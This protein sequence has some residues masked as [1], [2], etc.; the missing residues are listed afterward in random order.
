MFNNFINRYDFT[1]FILGLRHG[2]LPKILS[3][4]TKGKVGR[5]KEAWKDEKEKNAKATTWW[6]IPAICQRYNHL[7]T[8]NENVDY[9]HYVAS[10]Y[11]NG[12]NGLK[13]LSLGCGTGHRERMWACL[14]DFKKIEGYDISEGLIQKAREEATKKDFKGILE[15]QAADILKLDFKENTYDAIFVEHSLHH[16]SPLED[17]LVKINNC[18]KPDGFFV[19]NE[20]VGP[21]RFQWTDRQLE[22]ANGVLSILPNKYRRHV[23][24]GHQ[25]KKIIR[26]S[27]LSMI[28]KDPSEAIESGEIMPLIEKTFDVV[29]IRPY[30]GAI[31]HLL[32]DGIAGNFVED[33]EETKRIFHLCL[34]IE[35]LMTETGE[36][37]SDYVLAICRKRINK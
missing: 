36:V 33:D 18:L 32:F 11:F 8:G 9:Y 13:G 17:L 37:D 24:Y 3:R 34:E 2:Y 31:L 21:S 29:E 27:K 23:V 14:C 10:K 15:Y 28:L 19:I 5:V 16:F 26:P 1:R 7:I 12:K 25:I 20:Y 6:M 35:D 22:I 30:Y 4:I